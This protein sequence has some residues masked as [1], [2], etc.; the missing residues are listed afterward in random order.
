M[1]YFTPPKP[2]H[3]DSIRFDDGD[4]NVDHDNEIKVRIFHFIL[5]EIKR[6]KRQ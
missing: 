1:K 6:E 3:S 5:K 4:D 2:Y